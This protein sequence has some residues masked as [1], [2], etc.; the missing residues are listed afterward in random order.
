MTAKPPVP[1]L[2]DGFAL[3]PIRAVFLDGIGRAVEAGSEAVRIV[4]TFVPALRQRGTVRIQPGKHSARAAVL[5]RLFRP[6]WLFYAIM[7][8]CLAS[9]TPRGRRNGC[10][11]GLPFLFGRFRHN[12]GCNFAAVRGNVEMSTEEKIAIDLALLLLIFALIW[13]R[14]HGE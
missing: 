10:D 1:H 7:F 14:R 8:F 3:S 9:V 6:W 13:V 5:K 2:P 12:R 4:F 11:G